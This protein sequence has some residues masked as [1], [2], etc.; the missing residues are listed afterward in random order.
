MIK[1]MFEIKDDLKAVAVKLA[2]VPEQTRQ[3]ALVRTKIEEACMW[4]DYELR[5]Q[6]VDPSH[7][8]SAEEI[9]EEEEETS[10]MDALVSN[11]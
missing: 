3:L 10:E 5:L 4:A 1:E 8:V 7:P 9:E 11:L 2:S 6:G